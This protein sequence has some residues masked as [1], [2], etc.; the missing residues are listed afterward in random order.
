MRDP[1]CA[2]VAV[3]AFVLF[4]LTL[5]SAS[6]TGSISGVVTDKSG[7]VISGATVAATNTLTGVQTTQKTDGKG[8][9]NLPTL[10]VGTYNLE[11]K[12]VGFKTYRQTGLV[13]DANSALRADASLAVGSISEKIEVSTEAAQ[14]ETTSTQ[15]GEVIEGTKM[16]SVPLNGRSFIDLL[17]LQPGVSPYQNDDTTS[18]V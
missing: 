5:A 7:A 17:A 15:M 11:I 9:Y 13:I 16:T 2:V 18:G 3:L 8:F 14:V 12:Q 4:A 10:A 1:R 6:I